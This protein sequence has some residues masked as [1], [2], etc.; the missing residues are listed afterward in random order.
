MINFTHFQ[1]FLKI[2]QKG[3]N[4]QSW[5]K[6]PKSESTVPCSFPLCRE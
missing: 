1:T 6:N 4:F 2:P 3:Q 5:V